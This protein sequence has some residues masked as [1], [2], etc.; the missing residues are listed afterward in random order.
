MLVIVVARVGGHH[1]PDATL[2]GRRPC[3]TSS[4]ASGKHTCHAPSAALLQGASPARTP[5]TTH[6]PPPARRQHTPSK[7]R[8][9][10]LHLPL[11][12]HPPQVKSGTTQM[13]QGQPPAHTARA[14]TDEERRVHERALHH[15]M[16]MQ[17]DLRLPHAARAPAEPNAHKSRMHACHAWATC[18][19]CHARTYQRRCCRV[20]C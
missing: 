17:A 8:P 14:H 4:G 10:H 15:R 1:P 20:L 13:G 9:L 5:H 18:E 16:R 12:L 2:T 11:P 6:A 7:H 3:A 19:T